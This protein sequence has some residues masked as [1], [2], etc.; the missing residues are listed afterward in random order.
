MYLYDII[1]TEAAVIPKTIKHGNSK[2]ELSTVHQS[3]GICSSYQKELAE[4][5]WQILNMSIKVY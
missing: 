5:I 3:K 4:G 2:E 1:H